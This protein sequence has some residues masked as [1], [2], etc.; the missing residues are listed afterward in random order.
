[1]SRDLSKSRFLH[2]TAV[3]LVA[4]CA[5]IQP[6]LADEKLDEAKRQP[7]PTADEIALWIAQLDDNQYLVRERATQHLI[8][9]GEA[10]FD[11]LLAAA[12][13]ERPEPADRAVWILRRTSRSR[14]A[15]Q[16]IAALERLV[17]LRGRPALVEKAETELDERNIAI[18]QAKLAP[19]GAHLVMEPAQFDVIV[20]LLHIRLGEA[21][22][23]TPDDLRCI[24]QLRR[25]AHYR[26]EGE[27][28]NDDVVK[29]FE[30]KPKLALLYLWNVNVSAK[31]VDAVKQRHPD[32]VVYVRGQAMM[33]VSAETHVNGVIVTMVQPTSGAA[34]A[35][36]AVGDVIA[37]M[38]GQP[39]PDF[40]RLTARIAEHQPGDT[41]EVEIIRNEERKKLTVTLGQRPDGQ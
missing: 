15:T 29:F 23:G 24:V 17:Q 28:V 9:A 38:N 26:L 34:A 21:W 8:D 12:N 1:M 5:L 27:A 22:R 3:V 40:D 6:S 14:D 7:A 18:C 39:I 35:G 37:T 4:T 32:A 41:I 25:Q 30:D 11:A 20:P 36:V 16:A 19:L 10:A 13:S 33:G 2:A 31:A